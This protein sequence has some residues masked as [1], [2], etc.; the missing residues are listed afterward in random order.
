MLFVKR[1]LE[2]I[3][4]KVKLPMILNID[5][6][7]AVELANNWSTGGQTRHIETRFFFLW[8]MKEDGIIKTV[9]TQGKD[10]PGD[11]FTNNSAGPAYQKFARKSVGDDKYN[12]NK[13]TF[14]E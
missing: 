9:W 11:L 7:S 1:V 2:I 4:L 8:D 13:V 3:V 12:K 10:D 5:N 6:S 14:S